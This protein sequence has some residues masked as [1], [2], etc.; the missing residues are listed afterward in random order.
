MG[1]ILGQAQSGF[2]RWEAGEM[3]PPFAF[4]FGPTFNYRCRA[5]LH[6][7][8]VGSAGE[9]PVPAGAGVPPQCVWPP[10]LP[11][12][13]PA[14]RRRLR[15]PCRLPW[16]GQREARRRQKG[17]NLCSC[18]FFPLKGSSLPRLRPG[19]AGSRGLPAG[20]PRPAEG[21]RVPGGGAPPPAAPP[22]PAHPARSRRSAPPWR[23]RGRS[24]WA[25]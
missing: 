25:G 21:R 13:S 24:C 1:K 8:P 3:V 4:C 6:A 12:K 17:F 10:T 2:Y 5:R 15:S 20:H 14:L 7:A 9:T 11:A 23:C 19:T 18:L 22:P 16:H